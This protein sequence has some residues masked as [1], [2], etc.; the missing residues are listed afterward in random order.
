MVTN[1]NMNIEQ[2]DQ[3]ARFQRELPPAMGQ[4]VD[5]DYQ[6][7]RC[8]SQIY[9][10]KKTIREKL[11]KIIISDDMFPWNRDHTILQTIIRVIGLFAVVD[12]DNIPPECQNYDCF[13]MVDFR[14]YDYNK[15]RNWFNSVYKYADYVNGKGVLSVCVRDTDAITEAMEL[16]PFIQYKLENSTFE[17]PLSQLL[18]LGH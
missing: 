1:Y 11:E 17:I 3:L 2:L 12:A 5:R 4:C 8:E 9:S 10:E 14:K 6:R 15:N 13:T 18:L 16:L 7:K